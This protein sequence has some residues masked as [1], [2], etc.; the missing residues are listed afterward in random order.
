M[1]TENIPKA[2]TQDCHCFSFVL[3]YSL[4]NNPT[5]SAIIGY[6]MRYVPV[7]TKKYKTRV[8][9]AKRNAAASPMFLFPNF[10]KSI[11]PKIQHVTKVN[12]MPAKKYH[13]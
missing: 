10:F 9:T 12:P 6:I 4:T 13:S 8:S 1:K 2:N 3:M 11:D 5:V 7:R